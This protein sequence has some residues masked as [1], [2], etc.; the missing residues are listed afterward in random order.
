[1]GYRWGMLRHRLLASV[2]LILSLTLSLA[3]PASASHHSS[4]IRPKESYPNSVVELVERGLH[5][6]LD[7]SEAEFLIEEYPELAAV[8]PDYR[9]NGASLEIVTIPGTD[10][11]ANQASGCNT[12]MGTHH[13]RT[14]L[15]RTFY[16]MTTWVN[17]CWSGNY[18][19]SVNNLRTSFTN[20]A[21]TARIGG[22]HE[23]STRTGAVGWAKHSYVV[24]NIIPGWGEI[25]VKY[26]Y[27]SFNL[28]SGGNFIH[29]HGE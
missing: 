23:A 22:V 12:A 9:I 20:V 26:P 19:T 11:T 4:A 3:A 15:G 7:N 1:M 25:S 6:P 13:S 29:F 28:N 10:S 18:V 17:F 14:L 21:Y 27:N 8:I 5:G 24:E 16:E 2:T